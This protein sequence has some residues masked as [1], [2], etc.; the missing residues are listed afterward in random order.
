LKE[1][2]AALFDIDRLDWE[3][4][5]NDP[6]VKI[7][8]TVGYKDVHDLGI[9][10]GL[11]EPNVIREFTAREFLQRYGTEAHRDIFGGDFWVEQAM[12]DYRYAPANTLSYVTDCRF[13]NEASA[14]KGVGGVVVGIQGMDEETGGHASE[15]PLP[16][17]MIYFWID[18][19]VRGDEFAHLD[20]QLVQLASILGL[21][22]KAQIL[23]EIS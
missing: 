19:T 4:Y 16:D 14:I 8:L 10:D 20:Y 6:E 2:A 9:R 5:K 3:T 13:V 15:V 1:S 17:S 23:E 22:V 18:N 12:R 21:P 11:Q 7:F